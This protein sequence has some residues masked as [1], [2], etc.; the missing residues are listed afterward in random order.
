MNI[1]DKKDAEG[2]VNTKGGEKPTVRRRILN[3]LAYLA[4][5]A[6]ILLFFAPE[7]WWQFGVSPAGDRK[8]Q[9][10][11]VTQTTD[12]QKWSLA[13]K[14]GQVV[15]IN[16]WATWCPPCRLETPGLVSFANQYRGRGVEMAGVTM[17]E[18]QTLVAPFVT[19]YGI[20][21]PILLPASDPNV[22]SDGMVLPTTLLYDKQGRLAKKYTGMVL[23]STL[24]GDAEKLLTE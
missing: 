8:P 23:E 2:V 1:K 4:L 22:P 10:S 20:K 15:V 13:D 5:M 11:F 19:N 14:R 17:D 24:R 7:S 21:Y 3:G 18:D 12:G 16:Y 9:S 6:A